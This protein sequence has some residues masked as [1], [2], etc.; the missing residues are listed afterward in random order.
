MRVGAGLGD[1]LGLSL[2]DGN[3]AHCGEQMSRECPMPTPQTSPIE[4]TAHMAG[5]R[6]GQAVGTTG[7]LV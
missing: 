7:R 1:L 5:G 2:R 4:S 3:M 6:G